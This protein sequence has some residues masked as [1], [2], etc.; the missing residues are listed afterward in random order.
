MP[1]TRR[2]FK[3]RGAW[4]LNAFVTTPLCCPSRVS[5]LTGRFGHN[6]HIRNNNQGHR[7]GPLRMV[8]EKLR[9]RGYRTALF[10]KF[11]N[12]WPLEKRPPGFD[13]WAT[14]GRDTYYDGRWNVGGVI[15][16]I[17]TY[18]TTYI[19][20]RASRFLRRAERKDDKPWMMMLST[21]APHGPQTPEKRYRNASVPPSRGNEATRTSNPKGKPSYIAT[22]RELFGEA[23]SV[24]QDQLRTL[25]SVDDLVDRTFKTLNALDEAS[26]TLAIF[27]SDNGMLWGE[28]GMTGKTHA[29]TPS[30]KV[31][32]MM[33]WRGH[34]PA[35]SFDRRLVANIDVT[36]TILDA[37]GLSTRGT[38]GMSLLNVRSRRR[39]LLEYW[40]GGPFPTP[41]WKAIRTRRYQYV[42]Y[43]GDK[44]RVGFREYFDLT[45]DPWQVHNL[46]A[47]SGRANDP[48]VRRLSRTL[49]DL[50][51]CRGK[52]CRP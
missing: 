12:A 16:T 24:R 2:V 47:D 32:M 51:R 17:P 19:R 22:S 7:A 39:L 11:L 37:A 42:E 29:Y 44:G 31:P 8:Q 49:H 18:S 36:P 15:R 35:G 23:G 4:F 28:F 25:M 38:D 52:G 5:I 45:R 50:A 27:I 48:N 13:F 20:Q 40:K 34:V 10:G 41:T 43:Y 33:R 3:Q 6:H 26:S 14:P 30:I 1:S 46:L 9:R 21:T